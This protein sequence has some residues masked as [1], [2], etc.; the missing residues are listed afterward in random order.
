[1]FNKWEI[2]TFSFFFFFKEQLV[3]WKTNIKI[4]ALKSNWLKNERKKYINYE[5]S[6]YIKFRIQKREWYTLF[7]ILKQTSSSNR[8]ITMKNVSNNFYVII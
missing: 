6:S 3:S 4:D 5:L 7:T 8:R 2:L 1:M